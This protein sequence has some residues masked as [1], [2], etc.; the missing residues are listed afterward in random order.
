M[1][2]STRRT[3]L[4]LAGASGLSAALAG[5]LRAEGLASPQASAVSEPLFAAST[6]V[7]IGAA[8]LRV[9]RLD[10]MVAFYRDAIGLQELRQTPGEAVMGAGGVELLHLV[11]TPDAPFEL[12]NEAGLFHVAFLM[13]SRLSLARWLVHAAHRRIP[14]TGFADHSVSEA[15]YLPDP[16]GNGLEIYSD[17]PNDEWKW[18]NG[19]VTMGTHPLD[20]DSILA[21]TDT[22]DPVA[23]RAPPGMIIGHV[24]LRVGDI[25]EG[26]RFYRDALGLQS[27]RGQREDALFVSSGGYHHHIAM[28]VWNSKNAGPRD[29]SKTGLDWFSLKV[30]DAAFLLAQVKR[31]EVAYQAPTTWEDGAMETTDPWGTKVRLLKV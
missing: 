9:R 1:T 7:T 31:L 10:N 6:P 4:K 25:A 20:V 8:A 2:G 18:K 26:G 22:T 11:A 3:I 15:I 23:F 17:R 14:L 27:T 5:A 16:E 30:R 19:T 29:S 13:P 21:L 24:H 28:N 12:P